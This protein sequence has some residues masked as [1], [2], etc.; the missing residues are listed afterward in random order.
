MDETDT[1]PELDAMSSVLATLS[2]LE[3]KEMQARVLAWVAAKLGVG[4]TTLPAMGV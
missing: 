2:A 3:D 4:A 1:D